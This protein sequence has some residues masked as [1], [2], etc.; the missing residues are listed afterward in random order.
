MKGWNEEDQERA[1]TNEAYQEAESYALR[2]FREWDTDCDAMGAP[3][4]QA[5]CAE[6]GLCDQPK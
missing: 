2:I 4:L 6:V 3:G 5:M 1:L